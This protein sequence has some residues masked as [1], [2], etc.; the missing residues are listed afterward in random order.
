MRSW[1]RVCEPAGVVGVDAG[2]VVGGATVVVVV[3]VAPVGLVWLTGVFGRE[4]G[5]VVQYWAKG[6]SAPLAI[7]QSAPSS[8]AFWLWYATPL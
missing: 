7:W 6:R 1:A 8:D 2:A 5:A 4:A 3:V